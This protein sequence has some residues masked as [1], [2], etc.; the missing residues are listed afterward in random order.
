MLFGLL[1][2]PVDEESVIA[3]EK[4]YI[5]ICGKFYLPFHTFC[6]FEFSGVSRLFA[7]TLRC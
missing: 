2:S 4:M 5:I 7:L 1:L 3:S 6:N